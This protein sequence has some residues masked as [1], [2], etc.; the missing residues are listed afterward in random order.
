MGT[1]SS[2]FLNFILGLENIRNKTLNMNITFQGFN[3]IN[4]EYDNTEDGEV[5]N[6]NMKTG[7][8]KVFNLRFK[9]GFGDYGYQ[10]KYKN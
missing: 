10:I 7:E 8:K 5:R 2:N 3:I 1:L 6:I 4:P 9:P